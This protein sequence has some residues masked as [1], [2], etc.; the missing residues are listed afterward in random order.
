MAWVNPPYKEITGTDPPAVVTG[1]AATVEAPKQTG[2]VLARLP[3]TKRDGPDETFVIALDE[4]NGS[5][6]V[7]MRIWTADARTHQEFPTKRGCSVRL[8]E[9]DAVID[10]L[11][12]AQRLADAGRASTA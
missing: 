5:S 2:R 9:I 6:Y 8:G 4:L 10:A 12:S 7:A 11:R 1:Q 3:R